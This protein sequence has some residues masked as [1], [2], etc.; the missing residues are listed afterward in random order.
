MVEER[1]SDA[2]Y[3]LD[4]SEI[5]PAEYK[6]PKTGETEFVKETDVLDV[7]FDSGCSSLCVLEGNVEPQ[8]KASWP[9]DLYLEG[10]DQH[11]G[12]FN[13][14]LVIGSAIRGEAPYKAVLTH[15]FVVDEKGHKMSKRYGNVVDPVQASETYGAEILRYWAASV[16]ISQDVPCGP[17]LLK[18]MGESYRRIRNTLRFLLA[19]LYDY[20]PNAEFELDELD[21]WAIQQTQMVVSAVCNAPREDNEGG[22]YARYNFTEA[23]TSIHNFCVNELSSFYLDALKDRM[24]CDKPDSSRRRSAQHACHTILKSLCLA[25]APILPHTAEEVYSRLPG[26]G[27]L[28]S[29]H[30]ETFLLPTEEEFAEIP[31]SDVQRRF[32]K[33]L[34]FRHQL[35]A[36][37]E[38]WKKESGTKDSQD[39]LVRFHGEKELVEVLESF[40]DEL[41]NLLRVSWVV[42]SIGTTDVR[43]ELSPYEKCERSRIRR[44]DVEMVQGTGYLTKR[45]REAL[46]V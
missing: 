20:D 4:A 16:D 18:Q 31:E 23:I 2:W 26:T 13:R 27:K 3:Q 21:Q 36:L 9:A 30:L 8:W 22:A 17:E 1:G 46:G 44:P 25:L 12:W 35:G 11:R 32:A 39:V 37:L 33:L 41:P 34:E 29:V 7:W 5:L 15:G 45:D 42:L 40:G 6:H 28:E 43:F 10:S 14:S 19:N 24:Y 38:T